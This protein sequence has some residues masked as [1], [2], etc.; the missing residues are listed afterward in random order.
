[1][2]IF[3]VS[4]VWGTREGKNNVH[5]RWKY[6]WGFVD[7]EFISLVVRWLRNERKNIYVDIVRCME[8]IWLHVHNVCVLF[9]CDIMEKAKVS[10][11]HTHI[12]SC[13][14]K[15]TQW[16]TFTLISNI[17]WYC[18]MF[19]WAYASNIYFSGIKSYNIS[20]TSWTMRFVFHHFWT[21][22]FSIVI[23]QW[24]FSLVVFLWRH[25]NRS[26]KLEYIVVLLN[27]KQGAR[28]I[29]SNR[30]SCISNSAHLSGE[31]RAGDCVIEWYRKSMQIFILFKNRNHEPIC[32][33]TLLHFNWTVCCV[34]AD[35][36]MR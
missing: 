20:C 13:G 2:F 22:H 6:R 33:K 30:I 31:E 24:S 7:W 15:A 16:H 5:H 4:N 34:S 3:C 17:Y 21:Q 10:Y 27:Q 25:I 11:G 26:W 23:L 29:I 28:S 32:C 36:L 14:A 9:W 35:V 18:A 12:H 8:C 1:M 19:G